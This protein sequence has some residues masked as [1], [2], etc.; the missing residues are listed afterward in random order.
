MPLPR[1]QRGELW[2]VDL[3]HLG[4]VGPVVSVPFRE[5]ERVRPCLVIQKPLMESYGHVAT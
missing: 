5:N 4:K 1:I 3:G 2:L